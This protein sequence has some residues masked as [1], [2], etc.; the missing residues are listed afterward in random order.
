LALIGLACLLIGSKFVEIHPVAVDELQRC[1][2]IYTTADILKMEK[3]VLETL[4][5]DLKVVT[6]SEM[7]RCVSS[8]LPAGCRK[9]VTQLSEL[10]IDLAQSEA[11]PIWWLGQRRSSL[12]LGVVL[13]SLNICGTCFPNFKQFVDVVDEKAV[14]KQCGEFLDLYQANLKDRTTSPQNT[15]ELVKPAAFEPKK[16]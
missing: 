16:S 6:V 11:D 1:A 5:W 4:N 8:Q 3:N 10:L 9:R 13:A 12:A 2:P 14:Q 15:M 7:S